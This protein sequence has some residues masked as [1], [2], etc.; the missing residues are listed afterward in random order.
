[1]LQNDENHEWNFFIKYPVL[2]D[3]HPRT[4]THLQSPCLKA[5]LH[6]YAPIRLDKIEKTASLSVTEDMM[7]MKHL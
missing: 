5:C 2:Q 1:M 4:Q 6:N 7:E 3:S